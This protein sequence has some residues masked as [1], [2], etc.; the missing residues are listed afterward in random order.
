MIDLTDWSRE[1]PDGTLTVHSGR[2]SW[3]KADRTALRY[4]GTEAKIAD[5]FRHRF[6]A[7]IEEGHVEDELNRGL[8]RLWELRR[9][10]KNRIWIYARKTAS[11]WTIH[12]EQRHQGQNL[13]AFHGAEL[14]SWGKR[15][16]VELERVGD[17]HGLRV[18]G[19][20]SETILLDSGG[21]EGVNQPFDRIWIASTIKSRRNNGNWS[22]GYIE[23]LKI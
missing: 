11:G 12:F 9:D 4:I 14:F 3:M 23:N 1:D 5:D 17:R 15:Y 13:W 21:I 7:C 19:E 18:L 10:W 20:D 8:L 6:V 2:V 16:V 22:T